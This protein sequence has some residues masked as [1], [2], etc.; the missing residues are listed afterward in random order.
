MRQTSSDSEFNS[1]KRLALGAG[2]VL[3]C[4]AAMGLSAAPPLRGLFGGTGP[5]LVERVAGED[6]WD[7]IQ[8][9]YSKN[10]KA[11][12]RTSQIELPYRYQGA[13]EAETQSIV[14]GGDPYAYD[15]DHVIAL[16]LASKGK[17]DTLAGFLDGKMLYEVSTDGG[18]T[19]SARKPFISKGF[20]AEHPNE[21]IWIG[22]NS[23][24][25][26][27]TQ[28]FVHASNGELI[29]PFY[30][31]PLNREGVY[32]NPYRTPTYS[33]NAIM[34]GTWN[35]AKTDLTW[36]VSKPIMLD[37]ASSDRGA[38]ESVLAELDTKGEFMLVIRGSSTPGSGIPGYTW[39]SVS[40]DYCRTWSKPTPLTYS[41]GGNFY[42]PSSC[43]GLI[44]SSKTHKLYWVGN[45]SRTAPD[46]NGPRY[47]LV[48]AEVD[49]SKHGL[50]KS[51]VAVLDD[52]APGDD[53]KL[54]LSNFKLLE[55]KASGHIL[56]HLNRMN[57]H[58]RNPNAANG[59]QTYVVEVH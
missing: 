19:F 53:P 55:D 26:A 44:R 24:C 43:S 46:R 25:Y 18:A 14:S 31:A 22:K 11:W 37:S 30:Y 20:T 35:A 56:V 12:R 2:R 36:E 23:F 45:I 16:S 39:K 4:L 32:V 13:K 8:P 51:S 40:T 21:L 9:T 41:D 27:V 28:T 49:E 52:L 58:A 59:P 57:A 42:S 38:V 7:N 34:I 1:A 29:F 54:Q 6:Y 47:P 50:V 17:G 3:L 48:I 10:R 33:Q 5:K 15:S